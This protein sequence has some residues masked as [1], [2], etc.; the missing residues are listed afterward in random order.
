M[1]AE[2]RPAPSRRLWRSLTARAWTISYQNYMS[3]II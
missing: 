1:T 2:R 3:G